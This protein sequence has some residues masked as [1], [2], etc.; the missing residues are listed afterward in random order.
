MNKHLIRIEGLAVLALGTYM[1]FSNGYNWIVFLL[2]LLLPDASMLGYAFNKKAGA[3]LYNAAHTFVTPLLLL[4][5]GMAFASGFLTMIGFIWLAH[6]GMD[7][8]MGYGLKYETD[9]KDTHIQR[10]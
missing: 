4:F 7:R 6:I 1:Y 8:M 10:L 9:F 3:Y 2:L 5:A